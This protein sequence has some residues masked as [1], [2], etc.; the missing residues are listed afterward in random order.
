M[1]LNLKA[2]DQKQQLQLLFLQLPD[3]VLQQFCISWLV[4]PVHNSR[5]RHSRFQK[6]QV[7]H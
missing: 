7:N 6:I 1:L 2:I 5:F 3:Y 4:I